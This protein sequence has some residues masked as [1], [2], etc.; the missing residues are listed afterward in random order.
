MREDLA[1]SSNV[2]GTPETEGTPTGAIGMPL[3]S[4]EDVEQGP[5]LLQIGG[6]KTLPEP[7]VDRGEQ[8]LRL[9]A[10]ALLLPE[11]RQA[12]G[13]PELQ[14]FRLLTAGHRERLVQRCLNS[15]PVRQVVCER[16]LLV[17]DLQQQFPLEPMQLCLPHMLICVLHSDQGLGE[18][19]QARV[20]R[21]RLSIPFC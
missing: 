15:G 10:L 4:A 3:R 1:G 9:G 17:L 2:P 19:A 18:Q 6:I 5:G 16:W 21:A 11:P 13:G 20:R 8:R 14:G 7:T 12:H